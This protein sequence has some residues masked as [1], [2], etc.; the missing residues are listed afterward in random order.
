MMLVSAYFHYKLC[1][2]P[3]LYFILYTPH[4]IE[5][6]HGDNFLHTFF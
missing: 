4:D 2:I 1:A 5:H 3:F 6:F